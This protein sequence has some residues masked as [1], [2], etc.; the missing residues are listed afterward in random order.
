M[1]TEREQFR[2][3]LMER[4]SYY[5]EEKGIKSV[6]KANKKQISK[7]LT[8]F[9]VR[10]I[11]VYLYAFDEDMIDDGL[12]CDGKGD[13][14]IDFIYKNED[15]F[16]LIQTKY[17]GTKKH[18]ARDD[19]SGFIKI[20]SRIKDSNF[21]ENHGNEWV[22]EFLSS[23]KDSSQVHYFLL[24]NVDLTETLLDQFKIE[25]KEE[26]PKI[27]SDNVTWELKSFTE[28]KED[29]SK[30][31]VY[32]DP[33]PEQIEVPLESIVNHFF[34]KDTL[35]YLDL[36]NILDSSLPYET[37]LCTIKG[38]V[39]KDIYL[40]KRHRER[41]FSYNIRGFLGMNIINRK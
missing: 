13:L 10:E 18:L 9:Y 31:S 27:A 5:L 21:V 36:T 35:A 3:V 25:L 22:K 41:L 7:A 11:G 16:Y 29:Y 8:E 4:I 20:H 17:R 30:V 6:D 26:M 34:N 38:T 2:K 15:V 19:I 12:K 37:I 14:N 1:K 40:N 28:M 24:T 23:F 32:D 33:I 39:L